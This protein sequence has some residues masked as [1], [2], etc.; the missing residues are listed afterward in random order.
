MSR[1]L[2]TPAAAG[3]LFG[4]MRISRRLALGFGC[5][6]LVAL[7]MGLGALARMD[8]LDRQTRASYEQPFSIAEHSLKAAETAER[9]RRLNRDEVAEGDPARRVAIESQIEDLDAQLRQQLQEL[10]QVADDPQQVDAIVATATAWRAWRAE[11]TRL[12]EAGQTDAAYRRTLDDSGTPSV[13]LLAQIDEVSRDTQRLAAEQQRAS[14][15]EYQQGRRLVVV[16]LL[17]LVLVGL[18]AAF[19]ISRS[20][21]QPL[22]LLRDRIDGLAAARLDTEVPYQDQRNELGE[23]ARAVEVFKQSMVGLEGQ[24]WL[25]AHV[26]EIADVVQ[27]ADEPAGF[28]RALLQELVPLLDGGCAAFYLFDEEQQEL[29]LLSSYGF[30]DRKHLGNVFRLGEGLV[31]QCALEK[32]PIILSGLPDDYVRIT[33]GLG[34]APPRTLAAMPLLG[35]GGVLG[36]VEIATFSAWSEQ[37][38][39]LLGAVAAMAGRNLEIMERNV[40]TR[41]LLARTQAQ[42]AEKSELLEQAAAAEAR[43]RGFLELAPDGVLA[44]DDGGRIV[45]VNRR[46]EELFGYTRDE[47]LGQP[48]EMLV[49]ESVREQHVAHRDGFL[50]TTGVRQMGQGQELYGRRK[51]GSLFPVAI[52]LSS[53]S[54]GG[55]NTVTSIIRDITEE[56]RAAQ[57]V[58]ELQERLQFATQAGQLG[59][60]DLNTDTGAEVCT[61]EW[62]E[63]VGCDPA[64]REEAFAYWDAHVHPEDHD[65]VVGKLNALIAGEGEVYEEEFRFLHPT[66]GEIWLNAIGQTVERNENGT[67]HRLVGFNSDITARKLAEVELREAKL[68]A[69]EATELKSTFL[70]NMSHEI[71]TPM[72]AVIGL[73]YLALQTELTAKQRDYVSKIHNAGTALLGIINDILD[74]SKIEAG[75]LDIETTDFA[76]DDVLTSVAT[77]TAQKAHD[78]GLELLV[79][80][81]ADVPP[82]LRGD[83]LRIGQIITNLVNNAVKF[84]EHGEVRV[85]VELLEQTGEQVKLQFE[86]ADTGMGM[87]PEQSA[88][89]FQPFVQADMSIT[90]QHGGTGLGLTISKRLVEMMGGQIWVESEAGVGSTFRFTAWL[91]LG[92][93][94]ARGAIEP[95]RLR[96][97]S[98]LVVDDN[99]A[100]REI[101]AETLA[102]IAQ[103][104]DAVASGR[105]A[106]AAVQEH[107]GATPY[108]VVFMDWQMPGMDGLEATR[109]IK[110]DPAIGHP[111]A[112]V[113][114]TAYGRDDVRA[115]AE[116]LDIAQF[117]LKPVTRSTLV[118]TLVTLFAPPRGATSGAVAAGRPASADQLAGVRVLLAEDNEINQQIAVELL[119]GVGASIEVV[120]NGRIAVQRLLEGPVPPPFDVVLMDLQMPELDGLGA[121]AQIRADA[122]FAALPI[123]AMTAHATIEERE[124]CLAAGMQ[125]HIAKPIDPA[126]LFATVRHHTRAAAPATAAPAAP[127]PAAAAPLAPLVTPPTVVAPAVATATAPTNGVPVAEQPAAAE[128]TVPTVGDRDSG[129]PALP[130]V[131]GL[132]TADGL[133]RLGGNRGLY[134]K[135]LRQFAAAQAA[136]PAELAALLAAGDLATAERQ[137]HTIKGVAGNL[138]AGAVQA[139]AGALERA[140]NTAAPAAEVEAARGELAERLTA[141]LAGLRTALGMAPA[142]TAVL[143]AEPASVATPTNG[144][145]P[146]G[147]AAPTDGT[148]PRRGAPSADGVAPDAAALRPV[149]EQLQAYL[150]DF[151]AAAPE[152]LEANRA[153][154]ATL[155]PPDALAQ[156]EARVEA[157]AF[158]EAQ[159][160]LAAAAGRLPAG[161]AARAA[162]GPPGDGAAA[163]VAD[164]PPGDGAAVRAAE[165]ES[166]D[167]AGA[168]ATQERV[169]IEQMR[170]YLAEFDAAAVELLDAQ[171]A[172]F[173]ALFA[174]GAFAE[175]HHHIE[176]YAFDEA[177]AQLDAAVRQGAVMPFSGQE[178]PSAAAV[179]EANDPG[180]AQQAVAR[181]RQY[182]TDCDV[183]AV[184]HLAAHHEVFR[185][186]FAPEAFATFE[187]RVTSFAFDEARAQLEEA[188]DR[189]AD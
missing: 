34:E 181:M 165:G 122:R 51:D 64:R 120:G 174:P 149:I 119:E 169:A 129:D 74:F 126:V 161:A 77:L 188:T 102:G 183:A 145:I 160:Q 36:V 189:H 100:A 187:Q 81:A 70:A 155:F 106:V 49:P 130:A 170:T 47:L 96:T 61:D 54:E 18:A 166:G 29:R 38:R 63:I 114:V 6:L 41:E 45:L 32:A 59:I 76:I 168:D 127:A 99:A 141:L 10:R 123:I 88:K 179:A 128:P 117:L 173:R 184:D 22:D 132:D 95:E 137:A 156:F 71:R 171:S 125:D 60:W 94:Q 43:F 93:V 86:V 151:D 101:L 84:T 146:A 90:R 138:G 79:D 28:G 105:E 52:S 104:V 69:E 62:L 135:L 25:K 50:R 68:R 2:P 53:G 24:R 48:V 13:T 39:E 75:K 58:R 167:G 116:R 107:D 133:L 11:T 14:E 46:I 111:P 3:A 42:E 112:V 110:T 35:T 44:V 159:A 136:A 66:K 157:F 56:K 57:E 182:L 65:R 16:F 92:S 144:A 83:P 154:F 7:A 1:V 143:G 134:L 139:A 150:A 121:T 23:I 37:Q 118:D 12:A 153:L 89:L 175:F 152:Y 186:R 142:P 177:L 80:V 17:G 148:S 31:G 113:M 115:E 178:F 9:M 33:S 20:I 164:G 72:N 15:A 158:E 124:R 91:G 163:R 67:V 98:A 8:Q 21:T 85:K 5:L 40:R 30:V 78:K 103:R 55:A 185:A 87:T 19:F 73:A 140:L 176:T 180:A 147:E 26:A 82:A 27:E 131:D 108:D 172:V 162:D 97:L 109:R 4:G